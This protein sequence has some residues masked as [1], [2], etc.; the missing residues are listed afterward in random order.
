[1]SFLSDHKLNKL[2]R[3]SVLNASIPSFRVPSFLVLE[4]QISKRFLPYMSMVAPWSIDQSYMNKI[5]FPQSKGAKYEKQLKLTQGPLQR[6]LK[7]ELM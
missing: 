3:P 7:G 6:N 5:S 4:K 2:W 1:M